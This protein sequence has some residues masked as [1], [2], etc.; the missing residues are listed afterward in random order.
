M[1]AAPPVPQP[2][3]DSGMNGGPGHHVNGLPRYHPIAMNPNPPPHHQMPPPEQMMQNHH[4]RH[5]A[6]PPL[7]DPHAHPGPP[8]VAPAPTPTSLEQIEARL[9]Q[10]EHEEMNRM[11][12]RSHLLA[13]RKREDEEFRRMTESAEAEEEVVLIRSYSLIR[14][15]THAMPRTSEDNAK[16]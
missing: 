15:N 8:P 12:A 11:A 13:I 16:D 4:F 9:R 5:F 6:P 3:P 7:H 14:L 2:V 1:T 10:L